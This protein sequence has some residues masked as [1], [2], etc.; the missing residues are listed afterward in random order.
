MIIG[1]MPQQ[2]DVLYK[3]RNSQHK[4]IRNCSMKTTF[5]LIGALENKTLNFGEA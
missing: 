2:K 5:G 1:T 4:K 3:K